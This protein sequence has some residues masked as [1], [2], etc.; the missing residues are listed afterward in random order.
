MTQKPSG[1]ATRA[2]PLRA[3]MWWGLSLAVLLA[4]LIIWQVATSLVSSSYFP[5]PWQI[6]ANIPKTLS[7]STSRIGSGGQPAFV[8]EVL[9]SLWRWGAGWVVG[10]ALGVLI[11]C[12]LGLS[13]S[14]R[15]FTQPIVEFLRAV[16]GTA[17]ITLFILLL[18]IGPQM[19]IPFIAFGLMWTNIINTSAAVSGIDR[20]LIDVGRVFRFSPQ[21]QFFQL[22]LPAASPKI[23]A[24]VRISLTSALLIGVVSEFM[25]ATNGMGFMIIQTQRRFHF[26][27][28]WSWMLL[29]AVAGFLI[30]TAYEAVEHRILRWYLSSRQQGGN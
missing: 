24:G 6:I 25:G 16:P 18:G 28:M 27:D 15:E 7:S 11:G 26:L 19:Q 30:N 1:A 22:V 4:L 3:H 12:G 2:R 17:T 5:T 9:S 10:V 21:K 29:L 8:T 14:A 13:R 23:F 20:T